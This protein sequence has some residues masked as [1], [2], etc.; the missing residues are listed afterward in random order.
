MNKQEEVQ[1]EAVKVRER[2]IAASNAKKEA[3]KLITN[4]LEAFK[5]ATTIGHQ[6]DTNDIRA[7]DDVL[8]AFVTVIKTQ[9]VF[10]E[11]QARDQFYLAQEM[12][13]LQGGLYQTAAQLETIQGVLVTKAQITEA[14]LQAQWEKVV[15]ATKASLAEE[16]SNIVQLPTKS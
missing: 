8:N 14:E 11:Q 10:M 12:N 13:G 5:E 3:V 9:D 15:S 4:K 6:L 2:L 7:I 16:P 1:Q